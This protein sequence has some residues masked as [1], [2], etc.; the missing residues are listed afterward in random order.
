MT[1]GITDSLAYWAMLL[2]PC[3]F[4]GAYHYYKDRKKPE[5]ILMLVLAIV[6]GYLSA[7]LGIFMYLALQAAGIDH[8]PFIMAQY[9]LSGLFWYCILVIGPIEELAK[10]LPFVFILARSRHFDEELDGIIYAAF[11]ALGFALN[12]NRFYLS[13]LEGGQAVARSLISPIIHALFASVWGYAYGFSGRFKI[14]HWLTITLGLLL[15]MFLHGIYDFYAFSISIYGAL[16]PPL[17][18]LLIWIWRMY[19]IRRHTDSLVQ[20]EGKEDSQ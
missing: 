5:P 7:H 17:I 4:W 8:N 6:L 13:M 2:V 9:N 3:F 1:A 11:I 12:E 18:V 19:T 20:V 15:A 10:F 16:Y 14:P